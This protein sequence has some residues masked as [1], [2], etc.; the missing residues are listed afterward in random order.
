MA[1]NNRKSFHQNLDD[2]ARELRLA[3]GDVFEL[4]AESKQSDGE[5]Y[6]WKT[7]E[8]GNAGAQAWAQTFSD[9]PRVADVKVINE[10]VRTTATMVDA[11]LRPMMAYEEDERFGGTL[12]D[13]MVF[14]FALGAIVQLYATTVADGANPREQ[15]MQRSFADLGKEWARRAINATE[16]RSSGNGMSVSIHGENGSVMLSV[17]AE[18]ASEFE[19][20]KGRD[21][22]RAVRDAARGRTR[23]DA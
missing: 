1:K 11:V 23:G 21:I 19:G 15:L 8:H 12:L 4:D 2:A 3:R 10:C 9:A 17:E 5:S 14:S 7:T 6:K 20:S 18:R 22:A 16:T 13:E